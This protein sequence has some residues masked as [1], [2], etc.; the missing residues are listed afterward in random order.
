MSKANMRT[1]FVWMVAVA[2]AALLAVALAQGEEETGVPAETSWKAAEELIRRGR[3][4]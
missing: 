3:G 1:R 4:S 2:F